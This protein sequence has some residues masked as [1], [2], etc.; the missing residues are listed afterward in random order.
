MYQPQPRFDLLR[1]PLLGRWLRWRWGRLLFQIPLLLLALL[2]IYDGFTGPKIA[3]QNVATVTAWVHYRGLVMLAL[4]LVGNLFCMSCPFTLPRT[5]AHRLSGNGRRWPQALR[6][7]WVA[8]AVLVL[9]FF[10][11]EW[12]DL[13]ASPWLTAWVIVGYFLA[14]FLLEAVFAESP[15]C[16][17]VCPLGS[18]NFVSSTVSPF[19]ITTRDAE[20]CRTCPGKEC[21]NGSPQAL[22]CGTE[23]FVPQIQSNMDCVFCLDCARACPYDNVAL[24]A[25][26]PGEELTQGAWPRRWDMAF[27]VLVFAFAGVSNAF[28]MV[29][30][31]YALEQWLAARL[32][33]TNEGVLLLIIFG[34][35][36]VLLPAGV[37]LGTAWLSRRLTRKRE[38]LRVALSR[39]TPTVMPLAFSIWLAHYGFHFATGA[40]AIIPVTQNFLL[41][42]G[43]N[44]LGTAPTWSLA[45]LLP[46]SWLLPL[47]V[48]IMLAGFGGSLMVA[49]E[50]S[51]RDF[52]DR[53]TAMLSLL[54]WV[55]VLLS[56]AVA[57]LV[58]FNLPMEMRGTI[59]LNG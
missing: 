32:H 29:P 19:Q 11:Y 10:L 52:A 1:L 3:G 56:L 20:T 34:V 47:Q 54:P 50:I 12:L 15:F 18:F 55:L 7:K 8:I 21:V 38:P 49:D 44:W 2:M 53:R 24:A 40:L 9:F 46:G 33:I 39:Y 41:D 48:L 23:L 26:R 27:L 6:N 31:F 42:H 58:M 45:A 51:R 5:V 30:P 59:Q 28:G 37:G 17:Y 35:I 13:W 4:L 25:R 16:K 22:G 14:A 36:N 43:L 57:A